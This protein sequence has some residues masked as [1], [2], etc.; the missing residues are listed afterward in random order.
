MAD[1]SITLPDGSSRTLPKGPGLAKAAL[2]VKVDGAAWDLS[3]ALE[4]DAGVEI[5]T[6]KSEEALELLRH[7]A[8]HVMAEA[9]KEL[10]PD[11]QVTIGPAIED[12]FYYDFARTEPFTPDDLE[13]IEA[14]MGDIVERDEEIKREVW[15]RG[16]AIQFFKDMG[17]HYKAELIEALPADE[18]ITLYRQGD[19]ID[20]CRGPHL[21]ST[22]RLGKAF[23]RLARPEGAGRLP[24]SSGRGRAPR[25]PP[26][27]PRYGAVPH[28]GGSGGLGLLA[29]QGL[30]SLPYG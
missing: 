16:E 4:A 17:E 28:A 23:K 22:G 2:A 13:K 14:R 9:V 5:L 26:H 25:P 1:I 24:P 12:G 11:V 27:R 20:L 7:D 6:A 19:F 3:R 30:V 29:P 18:D 15:D 8:A 10:Y 21:P